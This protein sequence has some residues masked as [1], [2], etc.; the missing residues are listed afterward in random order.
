DRLIEV[1]SNC[2]EARRAWKYVLEEGGGMF[3]DSWQNMFRV[4]DM[5]LRWVSDE[6]RALRKAKDLVAR[7]GFTDVEVVT[8]GYAIHIHPKGCGKAAGIRKFVSELNVDEEII[9]VGDGRNDVPMRD[10]CSKLYAVSN[11]DEELKSVADHILSK[12]SADGFME[13]AKELL[14][15]TLKNQ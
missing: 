6:E 10:V 3:L 9:C 2:D 5:A 15:G 7:G 4:C 8:S 14:R 1:C 11:A 13:L 12:P